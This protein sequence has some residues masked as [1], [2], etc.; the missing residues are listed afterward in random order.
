MLQ[1]VLQYDIVQ[2]GLQQ[3]Q[4]LNTSQGDLYQASDGLKGG[5]THGVLYQDSGGLQD[6]PV[7]NYSNDVQYQPGDSVPDHVFTS[8]CYRD[9][10]PSL[11]AGVYFP[12][13]T[14]AQLPP[15]LFASSQCEKNAT[16]AVQRVTDKF[17]NI[18][19]SHKEVSSE[20]QILFT[21]KARQPVLLELQP[22][23]PSFK[24]DMLKGMNDQHLLQYYSI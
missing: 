19:P 15:G 2:L 4:T 14:V 1:N 12:D 10:P 6:E 9:G 8:T 16:A 17:F 7:L 20:Q 13:I 24:Q 5:A 21:D 18:S 22:M 11:Q 3:G 23:V